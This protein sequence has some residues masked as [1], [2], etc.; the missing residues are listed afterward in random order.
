ML[1]SLQGCNGFLQRQNEPLK[2]RFVVTDRPEPGLIVR[3]PIGS[4]A[5][6]QGG[7][8]YGFGDGPSGDGGGYIKANNGGE[9]M[10][11]LKRALKAVVENRA[12]GLGSSV[13][14]GRRLGD[15]IWA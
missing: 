5:G 9:K 8:G 10:G 2:L 15:D 3:S 14:L 12:L 1:S 7:D 13:M 6:D 4:R 11:Q